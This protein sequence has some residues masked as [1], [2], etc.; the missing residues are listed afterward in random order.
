MCLEILTLLEIHKEK[1]DHKLE[2]KV[3]KLNKKEKKQDEA[4]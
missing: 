2:I 4:N 1:S 3:V